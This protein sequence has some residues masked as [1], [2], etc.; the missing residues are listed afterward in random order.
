MLQSINEDTNNE[1]PETADNIYINTQENDDRQQYSGAF[2]EENIPKSRDMSIV[3]GIK[4]FYRLFI[5]AV[6]VD[7]LISLVSGYSNCVGAL[8]EVIQKRFKNQ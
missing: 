7:V 3:P 8:R 5:I 2:L 6:V 1:S 4:L